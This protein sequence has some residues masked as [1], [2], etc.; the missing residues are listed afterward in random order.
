VRK[1]FSGKLLRMFAARDRSNSGCAGLGRRVKDFGCTW[2]LASAS[3]ALWHRA[4]GNGAR[5][6]LPLG[7]G[8]PHAVRVLAAALL[9]IPMVAS[10]QPAPAKLRPDAVTAFNQYVRLT[11]ARNESEM[12]QADRW[13]WPELLPQKERDAIFAALKKGEIR[14]K[15]LETLQNGQRIECPGAMMPHWI[16]IAFISGAKLD[17]VL[18]ILK[19]YNHQSEYYAPDVERSNVESQDGERFR[20]FLRFRRRK[21]ITVVLNTE[22]E[23]QYFRDENTRAHSRS[24]A[25]RIAQVEN[26]GQPGEREKTPGN[27]DGFLWRMETWW[28]LEERDGGVYIQSEAATLTRDIPAGLGWL[29]EPFV[30]SIPRESLSFTLEATRKAVLKRS[31]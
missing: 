23:V 14:M 29:V 17:D 27:D 21:V 7:T 25:L 10:A 30:T 1:A 26:A 24:S 22:H 8:W 16:G 19:D 28:R 12:K 5:K 4:T 15:R 31:N 13:L 3:T 20:V 11:E 6:K 2:L 18:S 9:C